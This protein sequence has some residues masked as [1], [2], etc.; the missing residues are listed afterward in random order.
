VQAVAQAQADG[1]EIEVNSTGKAGW[2][3]WNKNAWMNYMEYR[4]RPKQPK[5]MLIKMLGWLTDLDGLRWFEE[6][7]VV[8]AGEWKRVPAEDKVIEVEL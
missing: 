7:A 4:G 6:G 5:T 3:P 8:S 2:I 1:W